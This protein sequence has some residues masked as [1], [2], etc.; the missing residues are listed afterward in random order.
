MINTIYTDG[1]CY[2][3]GDKKG[4][5]SFA[6]LSPVSFQS[7]CVKVICGR[8]ENTT[9]NRAEMI[10]IIQAIKSNKLQKH[11]IT[12]SGYVVKGLYNPSYLSKWLQNGWVTSAK[13]PVLN[14]D[15]W[16]KL[17][18]LGW[19]YQFTLEVM[20]GHNKDKD[21]E[22]AFWNNICDR[23]CT[24]VLQNEDKFELGYTYTAY[25]DFVTQKISL[26]IDM[27]ERIDD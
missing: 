13:K 4:M 10:A 24:Y 25:Y 22:K 17:H 5:G 19:H 26:G 27:A 3:T 2:N 15:L 18:R 14:K 16:R 6:Y 11:I 8:L 7:G 9:N 23:V 1:G 12:D 20:K 21:K